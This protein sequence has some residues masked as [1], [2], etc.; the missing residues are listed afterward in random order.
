MNRFFFLKGCKIFFFGF[1]VIDIYKI[2]FRKFYVWIFNYVDYK[3]GFFCD[4]Y[5]INDVDKIKIIFK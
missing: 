2:E 3:L 4:N 1:I 5:E